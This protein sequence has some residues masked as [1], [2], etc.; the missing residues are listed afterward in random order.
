[1]MKPLAVLAL[2]ATALSPRLVTA[3]ACPKQC[4]PGELRDIHGCC[5]Q[6]KTRRTRVNL[7]TGGGPSSKSYDFSGDD[8]EVD[9]G[10]DL[11]SP[12]LI[13]API[14]KKPDLAWKLSELRE[15]YAKATTPAERDKL[16]LTLAGLLYTS[17]GGDSPKLDAVTILR[18][19]AKAGSEPVLAQLALVEHDLGQ[20]D[21]AAAVTK[22]LV[23]MSDK[24]I[25]RFRA[26]YYDFVAGKMDDAA[27]RFP[28]FEAWRLFRTGDPRAA[29]TLLLRAANESGVRLSLLIRDYL[30]F[31]AYSDDNP[32]TAMAALSLL[33][34]RA[35]E[36]VTQTMLRLGQSYADL[37]R[38]TEA[39]AVYQAIAT[40][41]QPV[42]AATAYT[43]AFRLALGSL[44]FIPAARYLDAAVDSMRAAGAG[45]P[46]E[47]R[48]ELIATVREMALLAH[49]MF[50]KTRNEE[51]GDAA[52]FLY[53]LYFSLG[54]HKDE[55]ALMDYVDNLLDLR[56]ETR[57]SA[58]ALAAR[59]RP[60]PKGLSI[61][62]PV[63]SGDLDKAI[64]RRPIRFNMAQISACYRRTLLAQPTASGTVNVTM[65]IDA[66]TGTLAKVAAS[67]VS[68]ALSSCVAST[69]RA[70]RF[71]IA[72]NASNQKINVFYPFT[73]RRVGD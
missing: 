20:R 43:R 41:A 39:T 65:V 25:Y 28:Y 29:T 30:L 57:A 6:V 8:V 15:R 22:Q 5:V 44:G 71:P 73:F 34:D 67:G 24:P 61:G 66:G 60:K 53:T 32:D 47:D 11:P 35:K 64:I 31:A 50:A 16:G 19:L 59:A 45:F 42:A 3:Q 68:P 21:R 9:A 7:D 1:M 14:W 51:L 12:A 10:D 17:D 4:K 13:P 72:A 62:S 18:D 52:S 27:Y 48:D 38:T 33:A 49:N 40:N 46:R 26:A 37:G 63:V 56:A 36:D 69:I 58:R 2:L 70:W 23:A 54:P 55:R